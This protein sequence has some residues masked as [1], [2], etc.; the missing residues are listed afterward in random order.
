MVIFCSALWEYSRGEP[1]LHYSANVRLVVRLH[2]FSGLNPGWHF[3]NSIAK[4]AGE[5][6]PLR[7]GNSWIRRHME[8]AKHLQRLSRVLLCDRG[9]D[10]H[11]CCNQWWGGSHSGWKGHL[12]RHLRYAIVCIQEGRR[13]TVTPGIHV[14]TAGKCDGGT[15][16]LPANSRFTM[17]VLK[18]NGLSVC[19]DGAG[20]SR[21]TAPPLNAMGMQ[22]QSPFKS[23]QLPIES[24]LRTCRNTRAVLVSST[25]K[26]ENQLNQLGFHCDDIIEANAHGHKS[27]SNLPFTKPGVSY[28]VIG[29]HPHIALQLNLRPRQKNYIPEGYCTWVPKDVVDPFISV[30]RCCS[31]HRSIF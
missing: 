31:K 29:G 2:V 22:S 20:C 26:T 6:P 27:V 15:A 14:S 8:C 21:K 3:A 24:C 9:L 30:L 5:S 25:R 18:I 19:I 17:P 16:I 1:A 11:V 13:L 28:L 4:G 12:I 7:M 10:W 23:K